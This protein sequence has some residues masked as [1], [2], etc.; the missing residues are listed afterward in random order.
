MKS[1]EG[2][3]FCERERE[4]EGERERKDKGTK[5]TLVRSNCKPKET[6]TELS[7]SNSTPERERDRE[8]RSSLC[9]PHNLFFLSFF[10]RL[11]LIIIFPSILQT[12]SKASSASFSTSTPTISESQHATVALQ[13]LFVLTCLLQTS[14]AR[15][16]PALLPFYQCNRRAKV[17]SSRKE[18]KHT[19]F[20]LSCSLEH[21]APMKIFSSAGVSSL[22]ITT[23]SNHQRT[24]TP[25]QASQLAHH[26]FLAAK[27]CD[28]NRD[29]CD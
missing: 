10:D 5:R 21:L 28:S 29:A 7:L 26:S 9:C 12:L 25:S 23:V 16:P 6:K 18:S 11:P 20:V 15:V 19:V 17:F 27:R 8:N 1:T 2:L 13:K 3:V 24:F 14:T 22:H 4:R